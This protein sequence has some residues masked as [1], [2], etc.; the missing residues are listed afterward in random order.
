MNSR[1]CIICTHKFSLQTDEK[2]ISPMHKHGFDGKLS[3]AVIAVDIL[4]YHD[5]EIRLHNA[6]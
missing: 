4:R 1:K 3:A 2:N 5:Q 6:Y